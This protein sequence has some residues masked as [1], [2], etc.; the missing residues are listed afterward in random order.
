[1]GCVGEQCAPGVNVCTYI[2]RHMRGKWVYVWVVWVR[3]VYVCMRER[4]A[5]RQTDRACVYVRYIIRL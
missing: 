4:P 2:A 3:S 1:V 5:D